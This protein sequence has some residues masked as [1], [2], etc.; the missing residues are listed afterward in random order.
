LVLRASAN[1]RTNE[2]RRR[3][4]FALDLLLTRAVGLVEFL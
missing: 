3:T 1:E 2:R 4:D